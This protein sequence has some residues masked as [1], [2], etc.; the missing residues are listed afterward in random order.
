VA[1]PPILRPGHNCWRVEP[2]G[3]VGFLRDGDAYFHAASEAMARAR[4]SILL[5]A[6]DVDSEVAV[7]RHGVDGLPAGLRPFLDALCERRQDLSVHI[8]AW[9]FAAVFALEREALPTLKLD[10]QA[11]RRVHLFLDD[12]H[13]A[14][15]SHHQKV[16]VVDDEVAFVGGLDLT[17]QR[18]DTPSH[19]P[20]DPQRR[21]H[22]KPEGYPPFHDVQACVDGPCARALGD[23]AR[24][25]WRLATGERLAAPDPRTDGD[26]WPPSLAPALRDV[27]VGIVRTVP[28]F[29]DQAE[30]REAEALYVDEID[31]AQE[32]LYIENQY[33]TSGAVVQA[34]ERSL[35]RERGPEIVIVLP[36][37]SS[38]WLEEA[39][40]GTL[41]TR[42][43]ARLVAADERGRLRIACPGGSGVDGQ[44]VNV[45][46]KVLIADG[47]HVRVG[48]S[49]LSN[50]SMGLDTECD[51]AVD[52]SD[53]A[54][55]SAIERFRAELLG[56]HLGM[57]PSEVETEL[58]HCAGSLVRL[59]DSRR[60]SGREL[61][62]LVPPEG[63]PAWL[64][65]IEPAIELVDPA[66]P[67]RRGPR[68]PPALRPAWRAAALAAGLIALTL[69]W[70]ATPLRDLLH[71]SELARVAEPA[72][73]SPVAMLAVIA[74]HA[75]LGLLAVPVTVLI[76]ATLLAFGPAWGAGLA[77]AGCLANAAA[78]YG[79][80]RLLAGVGGG[81][82]EAR[83][84]DRFP[85]ATA[86]LRTHGALSVA[87][88]RIVPIAPYAL[89]NYAAG[90]LRVPF[91]DYMAGTLLGLLPGIVALAVLGEGLRDAL[92]HPSLRSAGL[93]AL[94]V[95]AWLAGGAWLRRRSRRSAEAGS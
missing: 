2:A 12:R 61:V 42:G 56:E 43:I 51:V 89:M 3:R 63:E 22:S 38:G 69:L 91:R 83:V 4:R 55:R 36:G 11:H 48:S 53:A 54:S 33:F 67:P 31:A 74:A 13:P 40:M 85:S 73:E 32:S 25:R 79:V 92:E 49:N 94:L 7:N 46:S 30:T 62:P 17:R 87:A 29:E 66:R 71:P 84:R 8:L 45:H 18:W 35:R 93:L 77:L 88:V 60:G 19:V 82:I 50:R 81:S 23:L 9:D 39:T 72:R 58:R 86:L 1:A 64:G 37:T 44:R 21:D 34:L 15:A 80:G 78:G 68:R 14:T 41:R 90:I 59:V 27:R 52:A 76:V 57:D 5:L 95:V 70:S 47:V 24:E 6:W 26:A 16:L 10:W 28:A 20:G 65:A 75:V